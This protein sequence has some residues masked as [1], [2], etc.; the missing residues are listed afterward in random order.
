MVGGHHVTPIP[1]ELGKFVACVT[2]WRLSQ[3]ALPWPLVTFQRRTAG[4]L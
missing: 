3:S 4:S 1:R 2:F